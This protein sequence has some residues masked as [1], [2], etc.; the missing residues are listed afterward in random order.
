M[1]EDIGMA[2]FEVDLGWNPKS[3]VDMINGRE[4]KIESLIEFKGRLAEGLQY[5]TF[6][7]QFTKVRQS[8]YGEMKTHPHP[9]KAGNDILLDKVI[10]KDSISRVEKSNKL[11]AERFGPFKISEPIGKNVLRLHLPKNRRIHSV[12]QVEHPIPYRSQPLELAIKTVTRTVPI[13]RDNGG[14]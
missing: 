10:F 5:A 2:P 6:S 13:L 9:Y 14:I 8:A 12:V 4:S 7:H 3:P 11:G 1:Y